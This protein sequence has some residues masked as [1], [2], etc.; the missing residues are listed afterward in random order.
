MTGHSLS[1]VPAAMARS[2]GHGHHRGD[3][4]SVGADL[5]SK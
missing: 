3:A 5:G 4:R 1:E 2:V